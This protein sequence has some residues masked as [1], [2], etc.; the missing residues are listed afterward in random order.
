[1][2]D[3][4]LDQVVEHYNRGVQD[5]PALDNRLKAPGGTP[6]VLNLSVADK[7][8]LAAFMKTLDDPTLAGDTKFSSPFLK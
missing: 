4:A 5:G 2:S 1:M 8:A 6:R 7:S 3:A